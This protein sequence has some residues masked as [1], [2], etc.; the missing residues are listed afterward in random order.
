[1]DNKMKILLISP[2]INPD[3]KTPKGTMMPQL[4]LHLLHGLT[5]T[6]Y[7]VKIVE[8][9]LEDIH[10]DEECDLVGITCMT[11]NAPRA[12]FIAE[13]F[14]KRGKKV[15]LGGVHPTIL[16]DEALK[17]A[18]SV[19]IGEAEGVWEQL[20]ED[21]KKG[22]L[23]R[24]Y[25]VKN[26]SLKRYISTKTKNSGKKRSFKIMPI[27]TTRGCPYNCDFCCVHD[28]FGKTLRH[29]PIKNVV[30]DIEE[31]NGKTYMFLD[32]NIIGNPKYAKELFAAIKPLNIKWAGQASISFSKDS[33][34]MKLAAQSGC[35]GLFIGLETVSKNQQEKMRKLIKD[36][37]ELEEAIKKIKDNGIHVHASMVFGFDEDTKNTFYETLEFLNKNMI[38]TAS[39]NILTPY[40]GTELYN[41]LKRENRLI[42]EDWKYYNHATVVFKPKNL[43]PI[44]LQEGRL[45]LKKEFIKISSIL[46]R[47]PG[48][49]SH[50]L[51]HLSVNNGFRKSMKGEIKYLS[52]MKTELFQI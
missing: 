7:L 19:A 31:S 12:Y 6:E 10:F 2:C 36:T 24:V 23:K 30:R 48:N 37:Y 46:K 21:F 26:P 51:L 9:E 20:L 39:F 14:R 25:Q 3:T 41:R 32:D 40:P 27:M 16:P 47:L 52:K 34:L 50:P 4:S 1:M 8:E 33:E 49:L 44:E 35:A 42:T 13:Q 5:P 17:Y 45:W 11:G 43:T 18:D 15:V 22:K 28:L 38:G 29:I